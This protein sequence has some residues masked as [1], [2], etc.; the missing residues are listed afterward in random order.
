MAEMYACGIPLVCNVGVGDVALINTQYPLG[1]MVNELT[2]VG[3]TT[4]IAALQP[5]LTL[6]KQAIRTKAQTLL[7]LDI[8]GQAYV[9]MY[10]T[11]NY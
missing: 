8:A 6:P 5:L 4:A 2:T 1:V 7:S 3:Y 10:R 9:N 11:L